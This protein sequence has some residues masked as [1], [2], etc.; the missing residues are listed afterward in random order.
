VAQDVTLFH[1][2]NEAAIQMKI[3]TADSGRCNPN[4]RISW[5]LNPWVFGVFDADVLVAVPA[6]RFHCGSKIKG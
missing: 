2:R 5:I 6:Q 4:D 3:G 1:G